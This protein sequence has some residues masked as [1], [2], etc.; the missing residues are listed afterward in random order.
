MAV[1][2]VIPKS[3]TPGFYFR[4][5]NFAV[6]IGAHTLQCDQRWVFLLR[7]GNY[8]FGYRT[9]GDAKPEYATYEDAG[10]HFGKKRPVSG[11]C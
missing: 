2:V 1:R 11:R 4:K 10:W 7:I 5:K 9:K 3:V 8:R 6:G